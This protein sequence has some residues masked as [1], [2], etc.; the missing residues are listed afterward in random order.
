MNNPARTIISRIVWRAIQ[1]RI[2]DKIRPK[3]YRANVFLLEGKTKRSN[4]DLSIMFSAKKEIIEYFSKL[5]YAEKPKIKYFEKH[6]FQNIPSIIGKTNPDVVFVEANESFSEFFFSNKFFILPSVNFTLD[7]SDPWDSIYARMNR[8]KRWMIHQVEKLGYTYETTKDF[9][10][11]KL[12]YYEMYLPYILKKHNKSAQVVSFAEFKRLFRGGGLLLVKLNGEYVSGLVY[13]LHNDE[14]YVPILAV[15]ETCDHLKKGAGYAALYFL[16]LFAKGEGYKKLD[17]GSWYPFL[18]DG[19]F[20]YKKAWGMSIRSKTWRDEKIYAI[21]FCNFNEGAR[22]F[23]LDNP[24]IFTDAENLRGLVLLDSDIEDLHK[25]YVSGLTGLI[26]LCPTHNPPDQQFT[27][28]N[29]LSLKEDSSLVS[30][31]LGF[32]IK[33]ASKEGYEAYHID[34]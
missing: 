33:I 5:S 4:H 2:F 20:L 10:K 28:L 9:E 18:K 1:P 14:V 26:V 24:F 17:Y 25:I 12:F 31:S 30:S 13:T 11:L 21:K 32:F 34:F 15:N 29:K 22:D 8:S 6:T 19:L 3:I 27:Q 23:L 7:L 16:I